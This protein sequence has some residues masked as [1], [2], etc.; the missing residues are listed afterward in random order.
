M[1]S[2]TYAPEW[3]GGINPDGPRKSGILGLARLFHVSTGTAT[4]YH[5]ILATQVKQSGVE[6][7]AAE[8]PGA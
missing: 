5:D 8:R 7:A 1:N 3:K 2:K 4:E 6:L